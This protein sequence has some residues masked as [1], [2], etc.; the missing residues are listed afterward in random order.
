MYF[1]KHMSK[2]KTSISIQLVVPFFW[3]LI[4]VAKRNISV[5]KNSIFFFQKSSIYCPE[6]NSVQK[7]SIQC[8]KK[9]IYWPKEMNLVTE[10]K[11]FRAN[12][13]H[14]TADKNQNEY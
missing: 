11:Q 9:S 12:E 5:P 1:D 14:F 10:K 4:F 2:Q 3:C 6:N 8:R 7:K 13:I